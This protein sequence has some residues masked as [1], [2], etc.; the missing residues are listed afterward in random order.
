[1]V[2]IVTSRVTLPR[3][4]CT[5]PDLRMSSLPTCPSVR[6]ARVQVFSASLASCEYD[7][8]TEMAEELSPPSFK[9]KPFPKGRHQ[10]Q[11]LE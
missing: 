10:Q 6:S 9:N 5:F 8:G 1:M 3:R 11:R 7:Q 4:S 2:P